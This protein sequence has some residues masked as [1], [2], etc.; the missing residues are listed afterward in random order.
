MPG[1]NGAPQTRYGVVREAS[2]GARP[3]PLPWQEGDPL[4]WCPWRPRGELH[5]HL[6]L[7]WQ[8]VLSLPLESQNSRWCPERRTAPQRVRPHEEQ[9]RGA[10]YPANLGVLVGVCW[11]AWG[12]TSVLASGIT[13]H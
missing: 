3:F 13:G 10:P 8:E 2:W 11:G 7:V 5:F 4:P 12:P 6:Q 9:W 1:C